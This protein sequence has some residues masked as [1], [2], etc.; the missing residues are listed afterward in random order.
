MPQHI[1]WRDDSLI[2]TLPKHKCDQ[3][4]GGLGKQIFS[5]H[6]ADSVVEYLCGELLLIVDIVRGFKYVSDDW[7]VIAA[8]NSPRN[9]LIKESSGNFTEVSKFS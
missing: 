9:R 7:N 4:G 5:Q 2:V 1:N 8:P 3:T 6:L